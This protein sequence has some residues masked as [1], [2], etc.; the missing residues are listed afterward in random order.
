[1]SVLVPD[2]ID[3]MA[4]ILARDKKRHSMPPNTSNFHNLIATF[5]DLHPRVIQ[6]ASSSRAH[7]H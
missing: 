2:K 6:C 3:F 7:G 4:I 5:S 1:M